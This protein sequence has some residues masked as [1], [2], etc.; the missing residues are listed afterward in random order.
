[1]VHGHDHSAAL[2]KMIRAAHP[3]AQKRLENRAANRAYQG[4]EGRVREPLPLRRFHSRAD[5]VEDTLY[6]LFQRQ[7][8]GVKSNASAAGRR[9]CAAGRWSRR[10][11]SVMSFTICRNGRK[12]PFASWSLL[13]RTARSRREA[14]RKNLNRHPEKRPC[15]GPAVGDQMTP[16]RE[17]PLL[18]DEDLSHGRDFAHR[19][20][21][22]VHF[23]RPNVGSDL[24]AV[25]KHA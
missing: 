11:R 10:S 15:P 1:V 3:K 19:T 14:V 18:S 21:G 6:L 4:V 25:Q 22:A 5:G 24:V 9:D 8:R 23:R 16:F 12:M 7:V 13:R 17:G 2:R 20:D